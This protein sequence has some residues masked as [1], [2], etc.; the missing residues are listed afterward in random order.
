MQVK[1]HMGLT[2]EFNLKSWA[3]GAESRRVYV[4]EK[5]APYLK[6]YDLGVKDAIGICASDKGELVVEFNTPAVCSLFVGSTYPENIQLLTKFDL[7]QGLSASTSLPAT[8]C[9]ACVF[10]FWLSLCFWS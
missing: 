4:L 6:R 2:W 8:A 5:M 9:L 7:R 10:V 1:D 3:N